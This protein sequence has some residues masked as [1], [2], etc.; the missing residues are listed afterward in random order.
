[1][2]YLLLCTVIIGLITVLYAVATAELDPTEKQYATAY[3][4]YYQPNISVEGKRV[5]KTNINPSMSSEE[6]E[7]Y[8]IE[9]IFLQLKDKLSIEDLSFLANLEKRGIEYIEI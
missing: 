3:V 4:V 6:A 1:M 7:L 9:N 5:I 8:N 2:I